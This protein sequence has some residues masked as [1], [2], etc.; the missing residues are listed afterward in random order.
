MAGYDQS[1]PSS[2]PGLYLEQSWNH[3]KKDFEDRQAQL[4]DQQYQ[5]EQYNDEIRKMQGEWDEQSSFIRRKQETL[6]KTNDMV[7]AGLLSE[8]E[9]MKSNWITVLPRETAAAMEAMRTPPEQEKF[10][11]PFSPSQLNKYEESA[12]EFAGATKVTDTGKMQKEFARAHDLPSMRDGVSGKVRSQQSLLRQ[13][14]AWRTNIGYDGMDSNKQRQVDSEWDS[15]IAT[16]GG[17]WNWDPERSKQI[18]S[19]RAKGKLSRGYGAQF[20]GTP[21]AP[22]E[23]RNPIHDS[24]AR[25]LPKKVYDDVPIEVGEDEVATEAKVLTREIALSI[26]QQAGGDKAMARQIAAE[27][28]YS[29]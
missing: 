20:R 12:G 11:A 19:L 27:Q 22:T 4:A 24:I 8:R 26:M 7:A 16:Q 23:A 21:T 3:L 6:R 2:T 5:P 25:Q 29:L 28:G 14:K 9:A 10:T 15:W 18:R 17:K 1:G 13:Y